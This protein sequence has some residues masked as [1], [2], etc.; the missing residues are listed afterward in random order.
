MGVFSFALILYGKFWVVNK[1]RLFIVNTLPRTT[2]F[3][4]PTPVTRAK[5]EI[6]CYSCFSLR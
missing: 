5:G 2:A 1:F 3:L 6:A 4:T